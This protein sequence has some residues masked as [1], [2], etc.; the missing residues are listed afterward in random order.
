[1]AVLAAVVVGLQATLPGETTASS[2]YMVNS[3]DDDPDA[4]EGF[5]GCDT[6][7]DIV[8]DSET[9]PECTLRAAIEEANASGLK[10]VITFDPVVF[11]PGTPATIVVDPGDVGVPAGLLPQVDVEL[12]IDASGAGVILDGD[13][14]LPV[15]LIIGYDTPGL[16]F[17]LLGGGSSLEIVGFT[18][19]VGLGYTAGVLVCGGDFTA[20]YNLGSCFT[21]TLDE[22]EI[23]AVAISGSDYGIGVFGPNVN[24]LSVTNSDISTPPGGIA[25]VGAGIF[26]D[27]IAGLDTLLGD[28]DA[29]NLDQVVPY[30]PDLYAAPD[31]GSGSLGALGAGLLSDSSITIGGP[32]NGNTISG[33][34][35]AVMVG[36]AGSLSSAIN[37]TVSD[38]A[39][40]AGESWSRLLRRRG[41]EQD[42]LHGG[43]QW[44]HHRRPH[45]GGRRLAGRVCGHRH[46]HLL[47]RHQR[48]RQRERE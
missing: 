2:T 12:T 21:A 38:N 41:G 46:G 36:F 23:D 29:G 10:D 44:C 42:Q 25:G 33:G 11:P 18:N 22:I 31:L 9:V 43:R 15:G 3:V 6:G 39:V 27:Q 24:D 1:V 26:G 17:S 34:I 28:L 8:V 40:L 32:E 14:D 16:D 37:V 30:P 47:E 20:T 48:G 13:G 35:S 45:P 7:T 4:N 5:D 19:D